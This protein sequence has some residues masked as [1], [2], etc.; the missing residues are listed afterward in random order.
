MLAAVVLIAILG[1]SGCSTV[2]TWSTDEQLWLFSGTRWNV[3]T[4][5]E[6]GNPYAGVRRCAAVADFPFSLLLDTVV[7][8]VMLVLELVAD[9]PAPARPHNP[10]AVDGKED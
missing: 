5:D 1:G 6:D 7:S 2:A 9:K 8:P 4:F 3:G 10:Q